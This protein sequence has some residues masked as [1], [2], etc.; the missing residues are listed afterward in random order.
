MCGSNAS[1]P[2]GSTLL[3]SIRRNHSMSCLGLVSQLSSDFQQTSIADVSWPECAQRLS[4]CPSGAKDLACCSVAKLSSSCLMT[5]RLD[6]LR[7]E[8]A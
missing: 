6:C 4:G 1:C 8:F 7:W 2:S 5:H 3:A